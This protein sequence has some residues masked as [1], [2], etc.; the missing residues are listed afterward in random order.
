MT[1]ARHADAIRSYLNYVCQCAEITDA[2][3]WRDWVRRTLGSNAGRP[4]WVLRAL[5]GPAT[6]GLSIGM[7]GSACTPE[8]GLEDGSGGRP[9][10]TGG[11]ATGGMATGGRL[12]GGAPGTGG[13][14]GMPYGGYG[15]P[16]GG[17]ATGGTAGAAD[18]GGIGSKYGVP[19]GGTGQAGGGAGGNGVR[20]GLPM[21]GMSG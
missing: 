8:N 7:L 20:Y 16:T 5:A 13:K 14:Y 4:D 10:A 12:M 11:V 15:P 3:D 17:K 18:T 1:A 6:V 2:D 9:T 19:F 21:T